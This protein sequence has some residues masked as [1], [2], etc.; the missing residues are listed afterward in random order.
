MLC[1]TLL[2]GAGNTLTS[3]ELFNVFQT[4]LNISKISAALS[5]PPPKKKQQ[6]PITCGTW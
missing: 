2:N 5:L 1:G 4:D 6:Q 3:W